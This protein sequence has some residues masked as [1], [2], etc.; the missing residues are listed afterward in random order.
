MGE[1]IPRANTFHPVSMAMLVKVVRKVKI[2]WNVLT[3]RIG[4]S[5]DAM[6]DCAHSIASRKFFFDIGQ[7]SGS[8]GEFEGVGTRLSSCCASLLCS[9]CVPGTNTVVLDGSSMPRVMM[10]TA[11]SSSRYVKLWRCDVA[12][13]WF[14]W[15]NL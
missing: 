15:R 2:N 5:E 8:F 1:A 13:I 4:F 9:V 10:T 3:A 7:L 11:S 6:I 12:K 14:S